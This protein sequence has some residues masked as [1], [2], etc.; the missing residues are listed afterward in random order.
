MRLRSPLAG[1]IA[2]TCA[3]TVLIGVPATALVTAAVDPNPSTYDGTAPSLTVRPAEFVIGASIDAAAAPHAD[4]CAAPWPWNFGIPMRLRWTGSD[5]TSGLQGYD[6]WGFGQ[7]FDGWG[8]LVANTSATSFSYNGNNYPGDCGEGGAYGYSHWVSAKDNRGNTASSALAAADGVNVWQ[9]TG[10]T[11]SDHY[12]PLSLT[13]TGTWST[14]SCTCFNNGRTL[15]STAAG[16]SLT[17]QLTT[18][19][20]SQTVAIVMEKNSNRGV[21][22]VSVDG[23]TTS[24]VDTYA[25]SPTHRVILWQKTVGVGSHTL[26][27]TNAGTSGRSRIDVDGILLSTQPTG[28]APEPEIPRP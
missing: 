16:A 28:A 9:E 5:G 22:N 24:S 12:S 18:T 2:G 7:R 8:K 14:A 23:G 10:T 1:F 25:S 13:R 4:Y 26:K 6:V 15:T 19:K 17:Y 3:A 11:T 21:V 20:P 27:L